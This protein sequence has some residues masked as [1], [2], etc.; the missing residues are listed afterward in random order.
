MQ[1]CRCGL[2]LVATLIGAC[3]NESTGSQD[4]DAG[5]RQSVFVPTEDVTLVK[6]FYS[7]I[8]ARERLV[9]QSPSEWSALWTRMHSR[10]SPEPPIV[11]PDFNTEVAL[12]ATMG[13]KPSGGYTITI[14]S[15]T[16]HERGSIVYV[17]EKSPSE[18]CFTP[19]VLTQ[20]VHAIRAPKTDGTIWWRERTAVENC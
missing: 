17:T 10:Q 2:V 18:T 3:R 1:L 7:G 16:R 20:A 9:V 19:G 4:P 5:A 13:E 8:D 14:D 11:Q 12:V 15:V 6:Q